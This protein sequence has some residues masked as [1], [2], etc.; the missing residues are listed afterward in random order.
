AMSLSRSARRH[1]QISLGRIGGTGTA[2]AGWIL[3]LLG[4]YFALMA[5]LAV[6]FFGLLLLFGCAG[7]HYNPPSRVSKTVRIILIAVGIG[8]A[9]FAAAYFLGNSTKSKA[10]NTSSTATGSVPQG[11]AGSGSAPA[12]V[13]VNVNAKVPTL[14]TTPPPPPPPPPVGPPPPPPPL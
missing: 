7:A 4:L 9:A 11:V 1:S 6:G 3:G 8:A 14:A 10:A 12:V 5:A 2:R 13:Q